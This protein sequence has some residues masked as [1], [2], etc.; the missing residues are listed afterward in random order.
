MIHYALWKNIWR[1]L[2]YKELLNQ[3][4]SVVA[5]GICTPGLPSHIH[6]IF[7]PME[8]STLDLQTFSENFPYVTCN[9]LVKAEPI[10]T[11]QSRP[12]IY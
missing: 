7:I 8:K 6:F 1:M 9:C 5:E 2:N 12:F 10:N 11:Q 4:Y 3:K